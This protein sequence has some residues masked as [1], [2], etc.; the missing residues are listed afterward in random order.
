MLVEPLPGPARVVTDGPAPVVEPDTL[1][2]PAVTELLMPPADDDEVFG[3]RSPGFKCTVL[4]LLLFGPELDVVLPSD[5]DELDELLLS[6]C[7][8]AATAMARAAAQKAVGFIAQI[9]VKDAPMQ[10]RSGR[11]IGRVSCVSARFDVCERS[12]ALAVHARRRAGRRC[13]S[14]WFLRRNRPCQPTIRSCPCRPRCR[15]CR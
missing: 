11:C 13:P 7:A 2:P 6:A 8:A 1:P 4:Q 12:H 9:L 5:D 10:G 14:R 15:R 3:G